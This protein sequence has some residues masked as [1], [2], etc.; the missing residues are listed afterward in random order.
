MI[1]IAFFAWL[2]L[3]LLVSSTMRDWFGGTLVI[4]ATVALGKLI[5]ESLNV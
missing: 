2:C 4:A 5:W 1:N 3:V